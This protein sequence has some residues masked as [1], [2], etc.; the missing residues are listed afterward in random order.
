[1]Q[2]TNHLLS[3]LALGISLLSSYAYAAPAI[4]TASG[5]FANSNS[6][7]ISGGGFG[8]KATAAPL[9]W[10]TFE[11]GTSGAQI[12]TNKATIGQWDSGAGYEAWKYTTAI[13]HSGSKSALANAS[14]SQYNISLA[15][16][17]SFSTVYMDWW[18]YA[19]YKDNPSRNWKPWRVFGASDQMQ[20]YYV[21]M[22]PNDGYGMEVH[23]EDGADKLT[24]EGTGAANGTWYHFQVY[25]QESSPN[26]A[27]GT[28]KQYING[29]LTNNMQGVKTRSTSAHWDQIRLGHYWGTEAGSCAAN[30]GADIYVDNAYIDTSWA[31]VE[32]G[33]A[34][35]YAASTQREIQVPSAWSSSSITLTVNQGAF[36]SGSTAYLYVF[37][38][39]GN[40]NA[41]GYPIKIG[42]G[43]TTTTPPPTSTI[44][45]PAN[46]RVTQ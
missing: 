28:I 33:N 35:T 46:L 31:H 43:S 21:W 20:T 15:Q 36:A 37:D 10:D 14:V 30:S 8:T 22:C 25:L 7:T 42:S 41:V 1:M 29:V 3:A 40:V 44:D 6:I 39:S 32:I 27:N 4:S 18:V 9:V 2:P 23:T 12:L 26:S 38:S 45:A 5:T 17:G 11:G 19:R 16:N 24:W 13:A 34:A